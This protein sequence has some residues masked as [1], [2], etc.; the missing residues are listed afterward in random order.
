MIR[1]IQA[2]ARLLALLSVLALLV[3]GCRQATPTV[4]TD[5]DGAGVAIELILP[6]AP[7]MG[8]TTLGV[9]LFS[10]EGAAV[11]GAAVAVRGDMA[12]AGMVPVIATAAPAESAGEYTAPFEW[13]MAGDWIVTV[14]VT[15]P[16]GRV[17]SDEFQVTV[18]AE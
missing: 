8:E 13:T 5:E 9:R 17:V 12:H 7:V 15:L 10:S 6:D 2:F 1:S 3:A 14:T 18:R 11:A 4:G 16:D